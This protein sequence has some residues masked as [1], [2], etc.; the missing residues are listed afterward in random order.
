MQKKKKIAVPGEMETLMLLE[1]KLKDAS[2]KIEVSLE[3]NE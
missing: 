3:V 1:S 2:G